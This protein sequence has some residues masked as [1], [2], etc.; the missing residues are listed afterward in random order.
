LAKYKKTYTIEPERKHL[1]DKCH[2]QTVIIHP[3]VLARE[4]YAQEERY[5]WLTILLDSY[6][7]NDFELLKD[8]RRE[9]KS[10]GEK[11]ACHKGCFYCCLKPDVPITRPELSGISWFITE[12]MNE[13]MRDKLR[14]RLRL[15]RKSLECPLLLDEIC[16][17]YPVRPIACRIFLVY[18]NPCDKGEDIARTRKG[19]IHPP[20]REIARCVAMRLLD[21]QSFNLSGKGQKEKAFESGIILNSSRPM[22][23]VD[24]AQFIVIIDMHL[25]RKR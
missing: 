12:I 1:S 23:H 2:S 24:W 22:H 9:E 8:I 4:R 16:S 19:D 25:Q 21:D 15:H 7:I 10:R 6:A 5:A 3:A 18:G 20:N 17:I 11:I 14:L 13:D